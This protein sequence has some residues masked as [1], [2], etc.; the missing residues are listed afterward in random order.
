[1]PHIKRCHILALI[2][3]LCAVRVFARDVK[4]AITDA[5]LALPLEGAVV[6]T[7]DGRSIGSNSNG[8]V[9][10]DVPEGVPVS[11]RITYPGYKTERV[12]VIPGGPREI[13][14]SMRIESL[15]ENK[16]L[17]FTAEKVNEGT[18]VKSGRSVS[19]AGRELDRVSQIGFME[20]VMTAVKLLPGVG[21]TGMFNA[22]PSIRGGDPGDLMAVL[23]GFYIENPYFWGG[24]VS[25]FDPRMVQSVKLSHGIF[26]SRYGHTISGLLEVSSKKPSTTDIEIELGISTSA[27]NLNMSIPLK[28]GGL[29]IMGKATYWDGFVGLAKALAN[30]VEELEPINA[31]TVAPYIR[32]AA[33]TGNWRFNQNTELTFNAFVGGDGVGADY[34][35]PIEINGQQQEINMKFDWLNIQFF[36]ISGLMFNPKPSMV[37]R[38]SLGGGFNSSFVDGD[39]QE[40]LRLTNSDDFL[41][42]LAGL[43]IPQNFIRKEYA[44]D[45]KMLMELDNTTYTAQARLDFDYELGRG[46]LFAAGVQELYNRWTRNMFFSRPSDIQ[47]Q[48]FPLLPS[49]S[50]YVDIIIPLSPVHGF[51]NALISALYS[52][53][54]Y[55]SENQKFGAELGVRVDHLYFIGDGFSIQTYPALN[56]RINIDF[57]ILKNA[58]F[59]NSID[60]TGGTGLFSSLTNDIS[61]LQSSDGIDS[62]ELKQNRSW[63]SLAG[64]KFTFFEKWSLNIEGY[65]KHIFDRAYSIIK[66]NSQNPSNPNSEIDY[67]F[68]GIGEAWGIDLMLQKFESEFIDGWIAYTFNWAKYKNPLTLSPNGGVINGE[69]RFPQ[70]HR[71]HN[72]NIV[73]NIKPAK[74]FNIALRAGF[75]SGTPLSEAGEIIGY[76]VLVVRPEDAFFIQK[77]KRVST[78]SDTRRNGF[79]IPL[80]VKLSLYSFNPYGKTQGEIYFAAENVL[81]FLKTRVQNTSFNQYTGTEVEGSDTAN[82]QMPVPMLSFGFTWSY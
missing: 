15:L 50:G 81:A 57:N 38:A 77:Y 66:T 74:R 11:V 37:L 73:L 53:V 58:G 54:E 64:I 43:S 82:Y 13:A 69:W 40:I 5:D 22:M 59:M 47:M 61:S 63:T 24:G 3:F 19:I 7:W 72:L 39:I 65:Y 35:N 28:K 29:M 34:K 78:Y 41:A 12:T 60:L 55:K 49:Y 14:V 4:L 51:N 9:L 44:L 23:D 71:Y 21:Y 36:A 16:E 30:F 18:E 31:I 80:D 26:S 79:V 56:P 17:V 75:A 76:P 32:T 8:A 33:L 10:L 20:D 2:F 70:F 45:N 62:F 42:Y 6:H 67:F 46:F 52:L 1:M 25:I 48:N 68:D 27:S